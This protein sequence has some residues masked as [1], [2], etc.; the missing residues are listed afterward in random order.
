MVNVYAYGDK[1]ELQISLDNNERNSWIYG[2]VNHL[3][4]IKETKVLR[5]ALKH[6]LN[7]HQFTKDTVKKTFQTT[8]NLP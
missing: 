1:V 6:V 5:K 7:Q 3:L 4:T 2:N 8:Y